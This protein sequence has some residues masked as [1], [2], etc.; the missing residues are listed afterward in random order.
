M[1]IV[2]KENLTSTA[3]RPEASGQTNVWV[4]DRED[5]NPVIILRWR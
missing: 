2:H 4:G 3:V 1:G 5:E